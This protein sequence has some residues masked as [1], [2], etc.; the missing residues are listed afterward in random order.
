MRR[1]ISGIMIAVMMSCSLAACKA[2]EETR[3]SG[4]LPE[5][6]RNNPEYFV[7]NEYD[8]SQD[9]GQGGNTNGL[10][11]AF[12]MDGETLDGYQIHSVVY[13]SKWIAE[14]DKQTLKAA[15]NQVTSKEFPSHGE[16]GIEQG[17]VQQRSGVASCDWDEIY[18]VVG[19]V[20][21][22][23]NTPGF[24]L[25]EQNYLDLDFGFGIQW[26]VSVETSAFPA[27]MCVLF[28]NGTKTFLRSGPA[29]NGGFVGGGSGGAYNPS[30]HMTSNK[31]NGLPFVIALAV[32]KTPNHPDGDPDYR[33]V[34]IDFY[35]CNKRMPVDVAV[36]S[37]TT[38]SE[39]TEQTT[40][41]TIET[42][43]STEETD[44]LRMT[45]L[46]ARMAHQ[47][48]LPVVDAVQKEFDVTFDTENP[49][50]TDDYNDS[51]QSAQEVQLNGE[52]WNIVISR[53]K[54]TDV[55]SVS[56]VANRD[57]AE[58]VEAVFKPV[59]DELTNLY[60]EPEIEEYSFGATA[61][62]WDIKSVQTGNGYLVCLYVAKNDGQKCCAFGIG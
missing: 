10:L 2:T 51:Y 58:E 26:N 33:D 20:E 27:S 12:D 32:D 48:F 39:E 43:V 49:T 25:S 31:V 55:A 7:R 16:L 24:D 54:N 50:T 19:K 13:A 52:Q 21:L 56:F 22:T 41:T 45:R 53:D 59:Y 14:S 36:T 34:T 37:E 17:S 1:I 8:E 4:T 40:E 6:D 9:S 30:V 57:S 15:W 23:N 44:I 11:S 28:G 18:Y 29:Q 62:R 47:Y 42:P 60:G 35:T 3:V 61:Y 46:G 38:P 5:P